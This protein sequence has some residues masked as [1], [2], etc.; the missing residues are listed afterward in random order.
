MA[1]MVSGIL[2]FLLNKNIEAKPLCEN[3][4]MCKIIASPEIKQKYVPD[5]KELEP[6]KD[7]DKLNFPEEI[8]SVDYSKFN[9]FTDLMNFKKI[10]IDKEKNIF[11]F[12]R[13]AIHPSEVSLIDIGIRNYYKIDKFALYKDVVI[14]TSEEIASEILKDQKKI[15][16]KIGMV[17]SILSAFGWGIPH[18][19][20][21]GKKKTYEFVHPPMT[22]NNP[23]LRA[24]IL[25]GYLNNIYNK[26]FE[27]KE[28]TNKKME[29]IS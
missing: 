20:E 7:Y 11:C 10:W 13:K 28:V 3:C 26:Q 23:S 27:I 17:N 4:P 5:L 24:F 8:S 2:S 18:Y 21:E 16:G 25:N 1:G 19:K 15:S 29:F 22:Q 12:Q 9:S 14:K 6:I